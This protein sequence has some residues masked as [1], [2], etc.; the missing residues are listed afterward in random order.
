MARSLSQFETLLDTVAEL[1]RAEWEEI[2]KRREASRK[3]LFEANEIVSAHLADS[4]VKAP[5]KET[6]T[7]RAKRRAEVWKVNDRIDAIALSVA[8]GAPKAKVEGLRKA[9][10]AQL[11]ETRNTLDMA[12]RLQNDAEGCAALAATL[13]PFAGYFDFDT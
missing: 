13:A 1:S 10:A 8:K 11:V 12:S 2:I 3:L 6:P 7:A 5:R 9:I 4:I